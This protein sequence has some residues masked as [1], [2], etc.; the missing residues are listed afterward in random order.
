MAGELSETH[1]AEVREN[2]ESSQ[3][4]LTAFSND[5]SPTTIA[6]VRLPRDTNIELGMPERALRTFWS[7]RSGYRTNS[8]EDNPTQRAYEEADLERRY[9]EYLRKSDEAQE[10][11]S[12]I[13]SRLDSGEDI[14]LVCFEEPG[15]PC[16]RHLLVDIIRERM[17]SRFRFSYDRRMP[18][19]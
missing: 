9:L 1:Y 15:A 6:V 17:D 12:S 5:D 3:A 11:L 13:E 18:S 4:Q 10:A 7:Y 16:H 8:A 14:A 2:Y 19:V